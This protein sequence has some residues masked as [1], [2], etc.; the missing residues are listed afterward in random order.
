[1]TTETSSNSIAVLHPGPGLAEHVDAAV[2]AVRAP[3]PGARCSGER[4]VLV[5][6]RV[7]AEVPHVALV[8]L[9]EEGE[10]LLLQLA[11]E[12]VPVPGHHGLDP[13]DHL[14]QVGDGES[15]AV[16]LALPV[17]HDLALIG[18]L[19]ADREREH[20]VAYRE[21]RRELVRPR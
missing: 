14:G 20:R 1:V 13:V 18:E 10:L 7:L 3:D 4:P 5:L 17:L 15:D 21:W 12:E 11:F 2:G 6:L 9:G 16:R 8:V 19:G